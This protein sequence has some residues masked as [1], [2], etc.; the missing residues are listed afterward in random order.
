MCIVYVYLLFQIQ[1]YDC[2]NATE[3]RHCADN[4]ISLLHPT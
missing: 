2:S 3:S 4:S 1:L